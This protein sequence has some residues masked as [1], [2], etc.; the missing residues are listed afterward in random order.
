MGGS[1]VRIDHPLR[2]GTVR[3]VSPLMRPPTEEEIVRSFALLSVTALASVALAA[4]AAAKGA[5]TLT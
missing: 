2:R 4:S 5:S 1:L 3:G